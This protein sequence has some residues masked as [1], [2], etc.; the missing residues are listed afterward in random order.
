MPTKAT[1]TAPADGGSTRLPRARRSPRLVAA[2]VLLACLGG[3]GSAMAFQQASHANQVL[4]A[5]H[6]L[7]RG[8]TLHAGDL[9]VVTVGQLPGV[10]TIPAGQLDSLLGKQALVDLP[11]GSLVGSESVGVTTLPAG[12]AELGLKLNA[13]RLPNAQLP[14]GTPVQLV[15]V[16]TDKS[17]STL[18]VDATVAQAPEKLPDGTGRVLDVAVPQTQAQQVADL[19]AHD[20]LVVVRK[21]EG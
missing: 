11:G 18:V 16:S 8:T 19:A 17:S 10:H 12:S 13:G 21:S 9:A 14:V 6:T 15:Q 2:G 7:M 4:V 20:L 1:P 5:S 3:L